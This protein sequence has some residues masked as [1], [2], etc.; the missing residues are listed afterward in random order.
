MVL[1]L[2]VYERVKLFQTLKHAVAA[3]KQLENKQGEESKK[4][5]LKLFMDNLRSAM[6]SEY[7]L[8]DGHIDRIL[9]DPEKA[10]RPE[11]LEWVSRVDP[12]LRDAIFNM[13]CFCEAHDMCLD[14]ILEIS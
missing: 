14:L 6:K 8:A 12:R 4:Q 3:L 11:F 10:F 5:T 7:S 1:Q 2:K 13:V 9:A